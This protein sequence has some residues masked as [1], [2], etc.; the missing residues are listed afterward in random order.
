MRIIYISLLS[1]VISFSY[2][3]NEDMIETGYIQDPSSVGKLPIEFQ[4]DLL[5]LEDVNI[6]DDTEV[7]YQAEN[8]LNGHTR[9]L[10]DDLNILDAFMKQ[11]LEHY[12]NSPEGR[13]DKA[14][15]TTCEKGF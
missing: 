12:C 8:D 3:L 1:I 14:L 11:Q 9:S 7:I 10:D 2:G 5:V 15:L 6:K 13:K 4:N